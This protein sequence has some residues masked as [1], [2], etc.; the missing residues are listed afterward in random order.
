MSHARAG[1]FV[2]TSV[3]LPWLFVPTV[4]ELSGSEIFGLP[5]GITLNAGPAVIDALKQFVSSASPWTYFAVLAMAV[6]EG[7]IVTTFAINGTIGFV[8]VGGLLARGHLSP[9]ATILCIYAG[10][11]LGDS[12]TFLLSARLQRIGPIARRL[13]VIEKYRGPLATHPFRFIVLAHLTP[14]LKSVC[15]LAA[16]GVLSWRAWFRAEVVGALSGTLFFVG[17]GAVGTWLLTNTDHLGK[18]ISALGVI[19]L[20]GV[21]LIWARA[22]RTC[23]VVGVHHPRPAR[24]VSRRN[25]NPSSESKSKSESVWKYRGKS[26]LMTGRNWRKRLFFV[27]YYPFWHPVRWVEAALR[28]LPSRA[29]HRNLSEA[30]PGIRPGDLLV[31]RLHAPAPWGKWAHCA[32]AIDCERFCH[33][34]GKTITS[35]RFA[36]FPVRYTVAHLRV[37]CDNKL[38]ERAGAAAAEMVGRRVSIFADAQDTFTFSCVSLACYGYRSVGITVGPES[39]GRIVPDDLLKSPQIEIVRVVYTE[40]RRPDLIPEESQDAGPQYT[41]DRV[42]P[43]YQ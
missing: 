43:L 19:L 41:G 6:L 3:L 8:A 39:V 22:L 38:A 32:I 31:V 21:V 24:A 36:E 2:V 5:P 28:R 20:I 7:F 10:T 11:L 25:S 1:L 4:S 37:R 34:F 23:R 13:P 16:A 18:V 42:V 17:L 30:F 33:A 9:A 27:V 35:H 26:K 29:L 14:Y 15:A 12:L 40:G